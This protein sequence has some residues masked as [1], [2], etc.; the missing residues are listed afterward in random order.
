MYP[1]AFHYFRAQSIDDAI[2]RLTELGE[3]ARPLAGGQSLVP[4]MKLRF[5]R[6]GALVD[7][8]FLPGLSYATVDNGTLRLGALTCHADIEDSA[9]VSMIPILHDCAAGIADVQVRNRGTI[10]GS[11]AEADPSGDWM[12]VLLALDT[13]VRCMGPNGE[14]TVPLPEFVRDAFTTVLET[15]ELVREA[16]VRVP[17][18]GSGGA[19]IAFKRSAPVY[20]TVSAA[21]QLKLGDKDV[22]EECRILLGCVG[23]TAIRAREGEKQLSGQPLTSH[24]IKHTVEAVVAAAEPESDLRGSADYKRALLG[25]L[26]RRAIHAAARRARGEHV[27]VHHEYIGR[28]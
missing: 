26:V 22:C 17:A 7:L 19:Y 2:H 4:L 12:P 13:E 5:S 20:A 10:G 18:K 23:L 25:A 6:P 24:S 9:S 27:E 3:D 11:I 14:R 15:G 1:A 28:S 16:I 8:G 21:V